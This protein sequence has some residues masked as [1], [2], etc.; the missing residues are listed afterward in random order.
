MLVFGSFGLTNFP[1]LWTLHPT[2]REFGLVLCY[3]TNGTAW[4]FVLQPSQISFLSY[5]WMERVLSWFVGLKPDI[6]F[7]GHWIDE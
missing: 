1:S 4:N 6:S 3:G 2:F 5:D 7:H